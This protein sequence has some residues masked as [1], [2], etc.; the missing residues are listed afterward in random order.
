MNHAIA[1]PPAKFA[2]NTNAERITLDLAIHT[3]IPRVIAILTAMSLMIA[4][5]G[6]DRSHTFLQPRQSFF[7]HP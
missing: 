5:G 3:F 2:S 1:A 6:F 7:Q 4:E